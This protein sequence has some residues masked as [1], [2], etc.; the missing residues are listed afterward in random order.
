MTTTHKLFTYKL[1]GSFSFLI[2][3]ISLNTFGQSLKSSVIKKRSTQYQSTQSVLPMAPVHEIESPKW[4]EKINT[5]TA[6]FKQD[7]T[8]GISY[9]ISGGIALA[10]GLAGANITQD[11]LEKGIYSIFQ[12]IGIA[13]VGYGAYTWKVGD[14]DRLLYQTLEGS[15]GLTES[16]KNIFIES[17]MMELQKRQ[18]TENVIKAITHGLIA[19]LNFYNASNQKQQGVKNTLTFIGVANVLA[20]LTYTF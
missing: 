13:S 7:R 11:P 6:R 8:T 18:Q 20:C 9:I 19:G 5:Q 1:A 16:Q 14:E 4:R 2:L 10:G 17:Y 3:I 15:S 12:T